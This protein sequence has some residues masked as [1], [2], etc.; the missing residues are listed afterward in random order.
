MIQHGQ[1]PAARPDHASGTHNGPASD[2]DAAASWSRQLGFLQA[3]V[4]PAM[5]IMALVVFG[6]AALYWS[7]Q[8]FYVATD[9]ATVMGDPVEI[10][11]PAVGQVRSLRV[12]VGDLVQRHQLLATVV[13]AGGATQVQ[14]RSPIDGVVV[15]RHTSL[16]E[17]T[18]PG[19]ALLVLVDPGQLWIEARIEEARVSRVR[20]GQ[21]A[22]VWIDSVGGPFAGSV[23]A[24]ADASSTFSPAQTPAAGPF[25]RLTQWVPVRIQLD[26]GAP[27]LVL[28][29]L[30]SV[31]IR[32]EP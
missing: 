19:R 1:R 17:A 20:V 31:R 12:D 22:E 28:G 16:G 8:T 7:E 4:V 2:L 3:A 27:P 5:L 9:N 32:V 26:P 10:S 24:V 14:L 23:I 11:A 13:L 15:A 18:Q 21:R 29:G 30:A 6:F 25:V